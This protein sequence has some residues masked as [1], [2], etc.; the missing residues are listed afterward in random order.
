M[1]LGIKDE[2]IPGTIMRKSDMGGVTGEEFLDK[3]FS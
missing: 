3:I 1:Y 2:R